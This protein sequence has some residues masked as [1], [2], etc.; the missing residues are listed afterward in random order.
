MDVNFFFFSFLSLH[1]FVPSNSRSKQGNKKSVEIKSNQPRSISVVESENSRRSAQQNR[2]VNVTA[3]VNRGN[4]ASRSAKL[5]QKK[6]ERRL[7]QV[8]SAECERFA[9]FRPLEHSAAVLV[10][11]PKTRSHLLNE[12][13][14]SFEFVVLN[15][16]GGVLVE[17]PDEP[18][19]GRS[20]ERAT[21]GREGGAEGLG[22]D[23]PGAFLIDRGKP[24]AELG[25]AL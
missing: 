2:Q 9:H 25:F 23:S 12:L 10:A 14:S 1:F 22:V 21:R 15:G 6:I 4:A 8:I 18:L 19:G 20:L 7:R 3:K 11:R 24:T 16:S 5:S 13:V 17:H